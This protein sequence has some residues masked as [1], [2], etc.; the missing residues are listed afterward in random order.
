MNERSWPPLFF[1]PGGRTSPIDGLGRSH[2]TKKKGLPLPTLITHYAVTAIARQLSLAQRKIFHFFFRGTPS[3]FRCHGY[4][5]SF[6]SLLFLL[7][8]FPPGLLWLQSGIGGNKTSSL[9]QESGATRTYTLPTKTSKKNSIAE[10]IRI[11]LL[12]FLAVYHKLNLPW[13]LTLMF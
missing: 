1:F 8:F 5:S 11:P 10:I 2:R 9:D 4:P 13:I 6:S 12:G 7:T 3:S